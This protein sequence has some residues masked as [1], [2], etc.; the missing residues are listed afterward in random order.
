MKTE[1]GKVIGVGDSVNQQMGRTWRSRLTL[2]FRDG[3]VDDDTTVY[4]QGT[5]LHV[6]SDHHV[7]KGPMFP[8]PMDSTLNTATRTVTWHEIHDS[9]DEVK[10]E[11][12]DLPDDLANGMMPWV[13]QNLP[14]GAAETKMSY[15]VFSP[16]PRV[17]K[18]AIHPDGRSRFRIGYVT[19]SA[20]VYRIHV[21]LGGVAGVVAPLIGK[22]PA[23]MHASVV[24]DDVPTFLRFNTYLYQDGPTLNIELSGPAWPSVRQ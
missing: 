3:S 8:K 10:T 9:K 11:T 6:V 24:S 13:L 18:L 23:D 5:T 20:Q 4:T 17:V 12:M 19:K 7:Q 21:E 22:A 2:R 15:V 1:D 16:K 14:R